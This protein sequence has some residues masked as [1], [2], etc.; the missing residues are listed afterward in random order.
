MVTYSDL[1]PAT[2]ERSPED[3]STKGFP[4]AASLAARS[5]SSYDKRKNRRMA[6]RQVASTDSKRWRNPGLNSC[7]QSRHRVQVEKTTANIERCPSAFF[8]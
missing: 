5:R 1:F 3:P 6:R 8:L 7:Y 2:V 4:L